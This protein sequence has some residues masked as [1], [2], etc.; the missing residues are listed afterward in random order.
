MEIEYISNINIF[1]EYICLYRLYLDNLK[2]KI[3]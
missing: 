3:P 2:I 1:E